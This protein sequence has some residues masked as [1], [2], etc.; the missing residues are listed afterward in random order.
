MTGLREAYFR[1]GYAHLRSLIDVE[2]CRLMMHRIKSDCG[3]APLPLSARKEFPNLLVRPAFEVYGPLYPPLDA[4]LWGL[5]PMVSHL[6]GLMLAPTYCYFRLYREGDR[7]RVHSDRQSCEH[8]LSL[9]LDYSDGEA[10]PLEV[11]AERLAAPDAHVS[12]GFG[13]APSTAVAMAVGDAVLYQGTHH[14]HGRTAPNPNGWSAHLFLH[15]VD[16]NGPYADFAHDR[17]D[18]PPPVNFSFA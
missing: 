13:T 10:W 11:S 18:V 15:W 4:F 3:D 5:T 1:N 12:D 14:R 16:R 8:S 2:S 6:T 7:C 9:T 17:R